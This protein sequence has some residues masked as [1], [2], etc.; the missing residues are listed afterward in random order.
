MSELLTPQEALEALRSGK[1]VEYKPT[2]FDWA[3]LT[4]SQISIS[5]LLGDDY[6]FRVRQEWITI[7]DVSFPKPE[8]GE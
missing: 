7:G 2:G 4:P 5:C 1:K 8:V 3:L 6:Q